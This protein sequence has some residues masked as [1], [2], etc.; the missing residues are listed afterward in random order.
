M[1]ADEQGH[2]APRED[3]TITFRVADLGLPEQG[4]EDLGVALNELAP[5]DAM[6][7]VKRGSNVGSTYLLDTETTRAGR[8]P[9]NEVFLDDVTVSRRHA[10][11]IRQGA[12]FEIVDVGSLNGTYLNGDRIDRAPLQRGDEVQIGKFKFVFLPGLTEQ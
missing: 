6:L 10:E 7:L 3:L 11:F 5:G 8:H 2:D 1:T 9:D 12:G 4:D